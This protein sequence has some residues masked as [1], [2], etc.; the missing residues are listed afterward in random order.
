[1]HIDSLQSKED[2]KKS[3]S[4]VVDVSLTMES[5]EEEHSFTN[6]L[7]IEYDEE[8]CTTEDPVSH[9]QVVDRVWE[10]FTSSFFMGDFQITAKGIYF[11]EGD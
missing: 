10:V 3:E 8:P 2:M 9:H 5:N 7:P 4:Q 6:I 11:G 1:M